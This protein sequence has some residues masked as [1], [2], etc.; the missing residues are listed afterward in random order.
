MDIKVN[1]IIEPSMSVDT[2]RVTNTDDSFK[3]IN[4]VLD[5]IRKELQS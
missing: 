1:Q 4:A 2:N 5:N 3:F